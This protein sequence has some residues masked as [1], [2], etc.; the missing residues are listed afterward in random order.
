MPQ[1]NRKKLLSSL[2]KKMTKPQAKLAEGL[3]AGISKEDVDLFS[4]GMVTRMVERH[5]ELMKGRRPGEAAISIVCEEVGDEAGHKTIV[6]IVHDDKA[7]LIDSVVARINYA[8]LLIDFLLHPVVGIQYG[9]GGAVTAV[10]DK[11]DKKSQRVSH[12]HIHIKQGLTAPQMKALK[13]GIA[14]ALDDVV[15]ANRDWPAMLD[16][17]KQAR[18]DL[19]QAKTKTP[20][21][22]VTQYCDFLDYLHDNNF[23]LL[24]YREYEFYE[25]GGVLKSRTLK[26]KS[27]GLLHNDVAP[28]YLNDHEEGLPHSLQNLRRT[29]PPVHVSKTNRIATVHRRV[30]MDAIAIKTY[31]HKGKVKGEK[32]FLGLFT[33]VT[34]SRSVNDVPYL[35]E[36]VEEVMKMSAFTDGSHDRKALR[37]ILEKYPRDELFQIDPKELFDIALNI[38]RLQERQRISLFTRQDAFGRYIS[39]LVYVPRDRFGTDLR[40][41][42]GRVLEEELKGVCTSFHTT[43]DDSVFAR[44]LFLITVKDKKPTP[45][46]AKKI[47][48]KLQDIG[49]TW[50][51]RLMEA[52]SDDGN[53]SVCGGDAVAMAERYGDAFPIAYMARHSA[54]QAIF[55]I[56]KIEAA[57]SNGNLAVD[58]YRPDDMEQTALRLKVYHVGCSLNLSDVLPI[59]ENMGLRVSS[60]FPFEIQSSDATDSVWVHDFFLEGLGV[61]GGIHIEN[62]KEQFED[63]FEQ[64]WEGRIESDSLNALITTVGMTSRE[65]TIL[66]TYVRYLKQI[67]YPF[68]QQYIESALTTHSDLARSL[69]DYFFAFFDPKAQKNSED[70][71]KALDKVI[72]KQLD[73]VD[74]LDQDQ[75]IRTIQALIQASLR[76]NYFQND[77]DGVPKKWLSIKFDSRE[78]PGMPKPSPFRDI[79]VYS[80]RVEA[81]HLRGNKVARGGLRWSDRHEDFRTEVLGLMKAQMVKNSVI[82]PV[83]SKGGFVVKTPTADRAAFREE[84]IACYKTF[85]RGLLDITDNLKNGKVVH[86]KN[87]V[88]RDE[89]DPYLVVAADKG[90]ASFSDIA[91]GISQE[92]GFWLDDAFAS[93]GS[94]GYDH[95]VMGITARGA[96]ESVKLH[97]RHLNHNIQEQDFDVVGVGD[98]GGDVF[99]NGMLL[100][101]H[102]HLIGSFN[103]LHIFCDPNP[104]PVKS[105][106]ERK[107]LFEA[108]KGWDGYNQKLLSKGGM[109]FERS[110]KSLNLTPEIQERFDI[111]E[112]S[113]SPNDLIRHML[114]ARTDLMWFGGIGTYIKSK[115]ETHLDVGDKANDRLRVNGGD[116]RAKV[117]GEGANLGVTQLGR[118]EFS[119]H[120]GLMNTD[121]IDNSGGVDS[122]DHEVNIK[123]LLSDVMSK[124]THNMDIKAR[125]KL[126]ETMTKDVEDLVLYNNYQQAQSVSLA[127]FQAVKNLPAHSDFI[128]ELEE[129]IDLD[130]EIEFLSNQEEIDALLHQGKGLSRP[131]LCV[132]TSYAKIQL[133]KDLLET[134]LPDQGDVQVWVNEYFPKALRVK[135]A[136]E[137]G[138][139]QLRRDI[140]AMKLA[141]SMV[142]RLGPSYTSMTRARTGISVKAIAKAY[143]IVS[144]VY[145]LPNLWDRIEA[146]DNK[147]PAEVQMKAMRD[148]IVHAKRS[149]AWFLTNMG[150]NLDI[151]KD[152]ADYRVGVQSIRKNLDKVLTDVQQGNFKRLTDSYVQEGFSKALARDVAMMNIL[153]TAP[154]IIAIAMD[155]KLDVL[156]TAQVFFRLG[157]EFHLDWMRISAGFSKGDNPWHNE[158]MNGLVNQLY[159]L[160]SS[161]TATVLKDDSLSVE[162]GEDLVDAWCRMYKNRTANIREFFEE[163]RSA[164]NV[165]LSMLIVAEQKLRR[166][167]GG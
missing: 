146:M 22:E 44:V 140:V 142:N 99:G 131:E 5:L 42:I 110:E 166:L 43:L 162:K 163:L 64:I 114:R 3:V 125:N 68:S 83:G 75:I 149:I 38:L 134:D 79:F 115:D 2:S 36:K 109:I 37:H 65:T 120:G 154:D 84:G 48:Q 66:R 164:G 148:V 20:A 10:T 28:V 56:S 105:F 71:I 157:Q 128:Q 147:V 61:N 26:G 67:R 14:E 137:I 118:M 81:V 127:E 69:V 35:R 24:G 153:A 133:T 117:I 15:I 41:S 113:V 17:L 19:E 94:V 82:V 29:L 63:A 77:E 144:E 18:R 39:C 160:Q 59:L 72:N 55:D 119:R 104:D 53:V 34:Y 89:D 141:N 143:I 132:L 11:S 91:N 47:E 102:I 51:E 98:M 27:L 6:D 12:L 116:V 103:H 85:I 155:E 73:K 112:K 92:Y 86:P 33:S 80:P 52:F 23:T 138:N 32:L 129:D 90:T 13:Q 50:S 130:R 165:D 167:Y 58:L 158:A 16:Q 124:K 100:S 76:T 135:Y 57:L 21:K 70:S 101:E 121:F 145:D 60:E 96:W 123:I 122:S 54:K 30:P 7:F 111:K 49:K 4:E 62:I 40:K 136:A 150:P 88:R 93:G 151:E 126:L 106:K 95:K 87:V 156:K 8:E 1:L 152:I 45:F 159:T 139:H 31:D 78:V 108:V 25:K 161:F 9:K 74:L 46:S 97:F 107:R